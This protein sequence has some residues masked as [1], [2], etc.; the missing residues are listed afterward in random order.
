MPP[1]IYAFLTFPE[2]LLVIGFCYHS[3]GVHRRQAKLRY[4]NG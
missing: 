1:F 3:H 4:C 2:L